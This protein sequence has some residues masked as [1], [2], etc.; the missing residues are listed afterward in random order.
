MRNSFK[1]PSTVAV[2]LGKLTASAANTVGDTGSKS[3]VPK[4][5]YKSLASFSTKILDGWEGLKSAFKSPVSQSPGNEAK[6]D[7]NFGTTIQKEPTS[8]VFSM[9]PMATNFENVNKFLQK[10][11]IPSTEKE[12]ATFLDKLNSI[13][14]DSLTFNIRSDETVYHATSSRFIEDIRHK[15]DVTVTDVDNRI[16]QAMYT[17]F[18][19]DTPVKEICHHKNKGKVESLTKELHEIVNKNVDKGNNQDI[20]KT[21][22]AVLNHINQTFGNR[23]INQADFFAKHPSL[24]E[25]SVSQQTPLDGQLSTPFG[26]ELMQ[27]LTDVKLEL[28][29]EVILKFEIKKPILTLVVGENTYYGTFEREGGSSKMAA[30]ISSRLP[31]VTAIEFK[32]TATDRPNLAFHSNEALRS[33]DLKNAEVVG[34]T[35]F[36]GESGASFKIKTTTFKFDDEL[37]KPS[38]ARG[39]A[40]KFPP[41]RLPHVNEGDSATL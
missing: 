1:I 36:M 2:T 39:E 26:Q 18:D 35:E 19:T 10:N 33:L 6:L 20:A 8:Q 21:I 32:S 15:A 37:D 5:L 11:E 22:V 34:D 38:K 24:D 17:S 7:P 4:K 12:Q 30:E 25:K 16:G 31:F 29:A 3:E 14:G 41:T 9:N 40:F 13:A 27:A 28:S 23:T